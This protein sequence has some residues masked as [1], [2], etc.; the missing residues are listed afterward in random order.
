VFSLELDR[1]SS[2]E[3]KRYIQIYNTNTAPD[4]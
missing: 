4:V 1:V 3:K 2:E